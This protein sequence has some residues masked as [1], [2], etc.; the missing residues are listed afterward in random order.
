MFSRDTCARMHV[1][2][3]STVAP[4]PVA[5]VT[6]V[7][8]L[9]Y[10]CLC[11]STAPAPGTAPFPARPCLSPDLGA[12][13]AASLP[14]LAPLTPGATGQGVAGCRAALDPTLQST[15]LA[16]EGR[17]LP[18]AMRPEDPVPS[19]PPTS[20]LCSFAGFGGAP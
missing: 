13:R 11:Y 10:F 4:E 19:R 6:P 8:F 20:H 17:C 18:S 5:L 7:C 15:G 14:T 12:S 16:S 2:A 9:S 1:S 3:R